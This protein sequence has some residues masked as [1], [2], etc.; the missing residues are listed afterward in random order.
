MGAQNAP[1]RL[2][3]NCVSM[4]FICKQLIP[5]LPPAIT[6]HKR[7]RVANTA[8]HQ[9]FVR[10]VWHS[11]ILTRRSFQGIICAPNVPRQCQDANFV[12]ILPPVFSAKVGSIWIQ[13]ANYAACVKS[14]LSPASTVHLMEVYVLFAILATFYLQPLT[15]AFCAQ[16]FKQVVKFAT[17]HLQGCLPVY[18]QNQ[19]FT[20]K[21]WVPSI[22]PPFAMLLIAMYV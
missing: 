7:L 18:K 9:L 1:L 12:P 5:Q 21:I 14:N 15:N 4:G 13:P 22:K 6:V 20:S 8:T 16:L 17:K 2:N 10:N 11:I 3:A 19:D